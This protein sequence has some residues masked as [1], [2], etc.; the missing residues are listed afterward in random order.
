MDDSSSLI[1]ISALT[2]SQ[3]HLKMEETNE[4]VNVDDSSPDPQSTDPSIGMAYF[5]IL[6]ITLLRRR[7]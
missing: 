2:S 3:L 5:L 6:T 7:E 1:L 4:E